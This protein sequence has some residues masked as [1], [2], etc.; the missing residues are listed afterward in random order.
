MFNTAGSR[1]DFANVIFAVLDVCEHRRDAYSRDEAPERLMTDAREK[2]EEVKRGYIEAGGTSG[3][4]KRLEDEVLQTVMGRYIP[5]AVE[6][7]ER[8]RT[9]FGVW[10][11]G[12]VVARISFA[13]AALIVGELLIRFLPWV[14]LL[15]GPLGIVFILAG[16]FY[17]NFVRWRGERAHAVFLN[18]LIADGEAFQRNTRAHYASEADY[19]ELFAD[20]E[21]QRKVSGAATVRETT[22]P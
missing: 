4:W 9:A 18:E 17:P 19:E 14:K 7:T 2:L 8:E 13:F 20:T 16:V 1:F 12:D 11:R 15:W 5:R 22:G 21:A 3:Y 10:R 6:Q